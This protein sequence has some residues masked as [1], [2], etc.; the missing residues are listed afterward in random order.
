[1]CVQR[2]GELAASVADGGVGVLRLGFF[3]G[4]SW[5][6]GEMQAILA[7]TTWA[8][9]KPEKNPQRGAGDRQSERGG[10]EGVGRRHSPWFAEKWRRTSRA[11]ASYHGSLGVS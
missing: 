6:G 7:S 5:G 10:E 4:L 9:E 2:D 8:K 11:P 1:M 3:A